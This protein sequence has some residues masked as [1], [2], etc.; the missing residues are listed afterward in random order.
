MVEALKIADRYMDQN[1]VA[2][3]GRILT[4]AQTAEVAIKGTATDL[5]I[6]SGVKGAVYLV[7]QGT[8]EPDIEKTQRDIQKDQ[9]DGYE[10]PD[11]NKIFY[12]KGNLEKG[13]GKVSGEFST[14]EDKDLVERYNQDQETQKFVV[15]KDKF[16]EW[17]DAGHIEYKK[18]TLPEDNTI[19]EETRFKKEISPELNDYHEKKDGD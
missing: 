5:A 18:D 12:H 19:V 7:E 3:N 4:P 13:G 17:E 1:E 9:D 2:G 11:S 8:S 14:T 15:P 16:R 10:E 6:I